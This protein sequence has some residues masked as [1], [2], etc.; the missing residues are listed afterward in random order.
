MKVQPRNWTSYIRHGDIWDGLLRAGTGSILLAALSFAPHLACRSRGTENPPVDPTP[1]MASNPMLGISGSEDR[2][3]EVPIVI[4]RS[5]PS[6]IQVIH[7]TG[8]EDGVG[9]I[10]L[11]DAKTGKIFQRIVF[12]DSAIRVET[13]ETWDLNGDGFND[14]RVL[15]PSAATNEYFYAWLYNRKTRQFEFLEGVEEIPNPDPDGKLL[16]SWYHTGADSGIE[17][18][19]KWRDGRLVQIRQM[20]EGPE[21]EEDKLSPTSARKPKTKNSQPTSHTRFN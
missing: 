13:A 4:H 20:A 11:R 2:T 16:R 10:D 18:V 9:W 7:S 6:L 1:A 14:L 5:L 19:F 3:I 8:Q 21:F 17:T 15:A 12:P